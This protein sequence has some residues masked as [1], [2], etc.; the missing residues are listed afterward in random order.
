MG[1]VPIFFEAHIYGPFIS[2]AIESLVVIPEKKLSKDDGLDINLAI[3]KF[4]HLKGKKK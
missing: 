2:N 4:K 1:S 3:S